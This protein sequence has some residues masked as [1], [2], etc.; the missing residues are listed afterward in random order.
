LSLKHFVVAGV[1]CALM[2]VSTL[3]GLVSLVIRLVR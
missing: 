3:L 2:L 1:L